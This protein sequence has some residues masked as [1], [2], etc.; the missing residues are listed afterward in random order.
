MLC[1]LSYIGYILNVMIG[2]IKIVV[3]KDIAG[4]VYDNI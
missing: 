3:K 2:I 4:I 1:L